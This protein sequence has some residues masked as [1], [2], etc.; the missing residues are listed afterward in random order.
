[1]KS[2]P[3]LVGQ[4]ATGYRQFCKGKERAPAKMHKYAV[5]ARDQQLH[6][7]PLPADFIGV[8]DYGSYEQEDLVQL[9][10]NAYSCRIFC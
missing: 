6:I 10:R 3:H 5:S 7:A 8:S 9:Q 1:M 2:L 4:N